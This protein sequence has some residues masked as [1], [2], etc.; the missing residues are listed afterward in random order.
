MRHRKHTSKLNKNTSHRRCMMANMLKALIDCGR[1][2]TTI[3]K[4]KELPIVI[5]NIAVGKITL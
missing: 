5:N 4:A 2:Q 3:A 1:I